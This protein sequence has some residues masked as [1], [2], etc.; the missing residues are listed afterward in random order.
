MNPDLVA[1]T[2]VAA[3]HRAQWASLAGYTTEREHHLAAI[4]ASLQAYALEVL[5]K[6]AARAGIEARY[7]FW[8]KR[9]AEFCLAL[10]SNAK[11]CNGWSRL[12]LRQA[13]QGILPNSVQWRRD[14]HDFTPLLL[15]SMLDYHRSMLDD[16]LLAN[17][18]NDVGGYVD[19][20]AVAAAYRRIAEPPQAANGYDVQAVWRTVALALWLRQL[21]SASSNT[22]VSHGRAPSHV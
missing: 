6:V 5:D 10:P 8:D 2:D 15:R 3:R 9:L 19:L 21:R 22:A 20:P 18:D 17:R 11:L 7:P 13:M 12:I 16:I 14:K 1:R 4:S